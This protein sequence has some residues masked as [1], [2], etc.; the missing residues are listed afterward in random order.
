MR[1]HAV[2]VAVNVATSAALTVS[3]LAGG[4]A[5]A[6]ADP[7]QPAEPT[8]EV[9]ASQHSVDKEVSILEDNYKDLTTLYNK[10]LHGQE[11]VDYLAWFVE[12]ENNLL[13]QVKQL[14]AR[15]DKK[16]DKE[17]LATLTTNL[18]TLLASDMKELDEAK[19]SVLSSFPGSDVLN[20]VGTMFAPL[21]QIFDRM[22]SA[23]SS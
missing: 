3:I 9:I 11:N 19:R 5:V 1:N 8:A 13:T 22:T 23:F 18:E 10:A 17:R 16:E 15:A 7:A 21:D 12:K 4:A 6:S 20:K 14:S 2:T